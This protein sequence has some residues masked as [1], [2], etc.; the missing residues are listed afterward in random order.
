MSTDLK[1]GMSA[2]TVQGSS[3]TV[4]LAGGAKINGIKIRKAD[5]PATNGV[6]HAI[7]GVLIPQ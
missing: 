7:E 5:F 6:I 2:A 1:E 3:V 4:S